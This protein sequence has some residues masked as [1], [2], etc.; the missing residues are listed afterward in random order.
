MN[1]FAS[2]G[3]HLRLQ[4]RQNLPDGEVFRTSILL[5]SLHW[6]LCQL[7]FGFLGD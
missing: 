1:P 2:Q 4:R 6:T 7:G 5:Q 3:A